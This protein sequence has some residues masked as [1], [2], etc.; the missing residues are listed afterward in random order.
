MER[1]DAIL[2]PA[3]TQF[4]LYIANDAMWDCLAYLRKEP[5]LNP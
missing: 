4:E 3:G 5:Q 1:P 2:G